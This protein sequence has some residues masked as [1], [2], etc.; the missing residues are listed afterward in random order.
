MD[1]TAALQVIR[2]LPVEARVDILLKMWDELLD[3]GWQPTLDEQLKAELDRRWAK[4]QADP[5]KVI[6]WEEVEAQAKAR[7]RY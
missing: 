2:A 7:F 3:E 4:Y 5:T 6:P 1:I